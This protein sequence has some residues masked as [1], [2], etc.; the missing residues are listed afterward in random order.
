[1]MNWTGMAFLIQLF[2]GI[3]I[4]L[5]FLNLLKGQRTQKVSID[6]ESKKEM[7]QLRSMRA[8]RLTE[9]LAEKVR[10]VS[11]KE[12]LDKRMELSH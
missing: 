2:F 8:I 6:R 4:G 10:P 3:V 12:L 7:D 11:F 1:M 5:Y 9:P